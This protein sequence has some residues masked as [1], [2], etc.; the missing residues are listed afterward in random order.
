M[1]L[2]TLVYRNYTA[3]FITLFA[4]LF[5]LS[6]NARQLDDVS[7]P[8][9]VTLDGT[10]AVLQLNGMGYRTK[11]ITYMLVHFIHNQKLTHVMR[12]RH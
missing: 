2:K 4:V 12:C 1:A 3:F 11:F 6:L 10:D 5:S 9:S 7:L 8:D